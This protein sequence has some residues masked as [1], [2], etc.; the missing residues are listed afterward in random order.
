MGGI[1]WMGLESWKLEYS[2]NHGNDWGSSFN[3]CCNE[4]GEFVKI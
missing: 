2:P 4:Y 3:E 1:D